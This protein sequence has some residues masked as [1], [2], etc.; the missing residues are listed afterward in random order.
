M[1]EGGVTRV[2]F[3]CQGQGKICWGELFIVGVD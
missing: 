2:K 3:V 1:W